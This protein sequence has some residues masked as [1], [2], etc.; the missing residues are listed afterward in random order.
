M[1]SAGLRALRDG[2]V[3][4]VAIS[5]VGVLFLLNWAG[6]FKDNKKDE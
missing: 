3:Y 4:V 1:I 6:C 5:V 2:L